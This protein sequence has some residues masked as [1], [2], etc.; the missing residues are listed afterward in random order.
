MEAAETSNKKSRE[1]PLAKTPSL[2]SAVADFKRRVR[3]VAKTCVEV[4]DEWEL[5]TWPNRSNRIAKLT[6]SSKQAAIQGM[7]ALVE[8]DAKYITKALLAMREVNQKVHKAA[9]DDGNLKLLPK[10]FA[11]K[12]TPHS[13]MR[14]LR[15]PC[16]VDDWTREPAL[17]DGLI[18]RKQPLNTIAC[19]FCL[20]HQDTRMHRLRVKF[21]FCQPTCQ[22][23]RSVSS[24]KKW[25]CPCAMPWYK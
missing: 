21:G 6:I 15:K 24:T 13:W 16:E 3:Q 17:P 22:K 11:Y 20:S 18:V 14:N 19:P 23:C 4:A 9:H 2:Q 25:H 1:S 7:P 10:P 12:G 5:Q 8:D